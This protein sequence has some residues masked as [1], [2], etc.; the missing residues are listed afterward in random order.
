MC[1]RSLMADRS[2]PRDATQ[3][4]RSRYTAEPMT[5]V[6]HQQ[7]AL[8]PIEPATDLSIQRLRKGIGQCRQCS[9]EGPA[10]EPRKGFHHGA[11]SALTSKTGTNSVDSLKHGNSKALGRRRTRF[12]LEQ[13]L[14]TARMAWDSCWFTPMKKSTRN[15]A[16]EA[17]MVNCWDWT[18]CVSRLRRSSRV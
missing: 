2:Y 5:M 7:G 13:H 15:I 1:T 14:S 10:A 12:G 16:T 4:R 17:E 18:S 11:F 6:A 9:H 8:N 3:A